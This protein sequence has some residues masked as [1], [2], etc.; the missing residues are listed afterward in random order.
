[1]PFQYFVAA[2]IELEGHFHRLVAGA[3][4]DQY[5]ATKID[6]RLTLIFQA[7]IIVSIQPAFQDLPAAPA[8]HLKLVIP[9][10]WRRRE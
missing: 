10:G 3:T 7:G 6:R 9:A 2:F 5:L 1:M 4:A 8:F